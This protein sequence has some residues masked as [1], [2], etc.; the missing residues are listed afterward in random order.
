MAKNVVGL[1]ENIHDAQSAMQALQSDGFSGDRANVIRNTSS[2]LTDIFGQLGIPQHDA[3][4]Y[5]QGVSNGGALIVLQR[6]GDDE[7]DR[8]ADILERSHVVDI[9]NLGGQRSLRSSSQ[10]TTSTTKTGKSSASRETTRG[11]TDRRNFYE[12]GDMVIP[13]IEEDITISKREVEGG[14]VRVQTRMEERPVSEQVTLREEEVHVERRP[15]NQRIDPSEIDGLVQEGTFELR[16]RDEE[17]VVSKE[18]RIVEEVVI[19][20]QAQERTETIQDTVRRTDVDVEELSGQARASTVAE[21][22]GTSVSDTTG[23]TRTKGK[24]KGKKRKR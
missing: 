18:A 1:F 20:K 5:H 4:L 21:V 9:D 8:A 3:E 6:L 13:I 17:A 7:A 11:S 23:T 12:G 19:N 2:G 16:E 10:E 22:S 15:V 24:G 14:G